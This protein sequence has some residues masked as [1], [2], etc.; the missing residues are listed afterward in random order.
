MHHRWVLRIACWS[1]L[2]AL[3]SGPWAMILIAAA[4]SR[5]PM[6]ILMAVLPH[7]RAN[8]L[9]V[10]TGRPPVRA[11]GLAVVIGVLLAVPVTGWATFAV[12][13][14]LLATTLAVGWLAHRKLGGQTG[15]ILGA[16][17]NLSEVALMAL[18]ASLSGGD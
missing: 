4:L 14:V 13:A 16:A 3:L 17:Q 2:V 10:L 8:G 18:F 11:V 6:A 5:L 7:A 12:A 9:S 15:D 1:L